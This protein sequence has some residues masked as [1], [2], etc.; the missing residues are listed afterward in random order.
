MNAAKARA[1]VAA[2]A[3]RGTRFARGMGALLMAGALAISLG[4]CNSDD[5]GFI[6]CEPGQVRVQGEV[7]GVR[8]DRA[9]EVTHGGFG[10]AEDGGEFGSASFDP[11]LDPQHVALHLIWN[12]GIN[13]DEV[14]SARG[15]ITLPVGSALPGETLCAANGSKVV[16]RTGGEFQY[17]LDSLASG[18][19]CETPR[20]GKLAGCWNAKN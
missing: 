10:Q 19:N 11:S 2:G 4:A 8:L 7:D 13:N 9:E 1:R 12:E 6:S 18:S 17:V 3:G 5:E 16:I 20:K 15:S 14:T